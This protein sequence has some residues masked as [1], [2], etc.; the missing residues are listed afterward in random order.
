MPTLLIQMI[1]HVSDWVLPVSGPPIRDGAVDGDRI[2]A[3]GP[4][5]EVLP[6]FSGLTCEHGRGAILPGVVNCHVHLEFS[7]LAGRVAPQAHWPD[8]L[9]AALAAYG[10]LSPEEVEA[11]IARGIDALWQSGAVLV[12]EVTN[13]GTSWAQLEA[14]PLAYHLFYECLGF[15]LLEQ[16]ALPEAFP[17]FGRPEVAAAPWVSAAAHAPYSVS[18][19]LFRA[20][21]QWNAC[22]RRPQMVHLAE[23][24]SELDFLA[25]G[26]GFC[27]GLLKRRGR[28]VSDFRPPGVSP[29]AYLHRLEFLGS[30]TL[31]VH[32]AWLSAGDCELLA[33]TGSWLVLCPR[34]NRYTGAGMPPVPELLDAGVNLAL[35]ADSLAGNWDLN[36]FGE[37]LWLYQSFPAHPGDLWLRLGTLNGARAL[38]RDREF[39]SLE[40]GKRAALGFIPLAGN[41]DFWGELFSAGAAGNFRWLG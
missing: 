27:Q 32:G 16:F 39:G 10:Q 33:A 13:T 19:A 9:E 7:G 37:M 17:F 8:W 23:S 40:P 20:V 3:V 24:R 26:D 22:R 29:P 38:G 36:L 14:G 6:G 4:A 11:G 25:R 18:A 12:G 30:R 1:A 31:T 5:A 34:A 28:W 15:N 21:A 35:G 41:R 2:A